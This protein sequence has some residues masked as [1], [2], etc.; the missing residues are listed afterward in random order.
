MKILCIGDIVGRPGRNVL[1][2]NIEGLKK[3]FELDF[4][5][6]NGENAAGGFGITPRIANQILKAGCDCIVLGDH[7]WDKKD[8]IDYLD[9][10]KKILRPSNFPPGSPGK[11]WDIYKTSSG[12]KIGVINLLGRVFIRYNVDCPFRELERAVKEIKKE[13]NIIIVDFHAEATSEKTAMGFFGDGKVSGVFGSH[14]HV[15]TAD[16]KILP[17]GTAYITDM[18]MTGP[19]DSVIGQKKELIIERFLT[20]IPV[21]FEIATEDVW[22][23]GVVVEVDDKTGLAKSIVRIKRS[24]NPI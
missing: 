19:Y 22:L 20:S 7:V 6:V 14:T 16:E 24:E 21:K 12:V 17:K 18:G 1:E 3:E 10:E 15:Q 5:I 2:S 23:H 4:I 8:L 9:D 11:G 13:T